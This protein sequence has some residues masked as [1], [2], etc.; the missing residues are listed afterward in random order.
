MTAQTA[1]AAPGPTLRSEY[2]G[3]I[4]HN[5]NAD[6]EGESNPLVV[7]VL[8]PNGQFKAHLGGASLSG[9]VTKAGKV[10]FTGQF[11]SMGVGFK[12]K[13]GKGQ[14]SATGLH[15]IGSFKVTNDTTGTGLAGGYT[16]EEHTLPKVAPPVGSENGLASRREGSIHAENAGIN[17]LGANY[18]G[19]IH[20]RTN[21]KLESEG[22]SITFADRQPNGSF[23]G[24]L[25]D[26]P[27][28]GNVNSS[29]KITFGGKLTVMGPEPE[30]GRGQGPAQRHGPV[31]PR[32][33]QA[34]RKAADRDERKLHL[35]LAKARDVVSDRR[36]RQLPISPW[37][38]VAPV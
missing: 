38:F 9:K 36:P 18:E 27:I 13:D 1:L 10:T 29:G 17:D 15:L 2:E 23:T 11:S 7:N 37:A 34:E 21:P 19:A 24:S 33:I 4:H 35:P 20:H 28:H 12:I 6:F 16:F 8:K 14:L 3:A 32:V 30:G 25:G 5:S 26:I 31:H 22:P